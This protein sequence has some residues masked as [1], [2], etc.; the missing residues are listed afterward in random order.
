M[1]EVKVNT[2][3]S[4]EEIEK[5]VSELGASITEHYRGKD[6]CVIG[7]LNGAYVFMA[8]LVRKIDLPITIDFIRAKSYVG[9]DTTGDPNFL[10]DTTTD[11]EGKDVLIVEDILDTG[12]TL[13]YITRS[14][15]KRNANSVAIAV[16]LDKPA[17]RR[18]DIKADYRGFEIE[19]RFV[20]GYGLDYNEKYRN[21]P[22]VA[23]LSMYE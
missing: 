4:T 7:V 5:R 22:F 2:L 10:L 6:L 21:L 11:F 8:D 12:I 17:R 20:V 9:K 13:S 23:E 3:I 16:L 14:F 15:L 1:S 19:D 18:A